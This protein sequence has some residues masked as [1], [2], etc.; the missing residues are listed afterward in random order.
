MQNAREKIAIYL[1]S[2]SGYCFPLLSTLGGVF[3]LTLNV[4]SPTLQF[5]Q[6]FSWVLIIVGLIWAGNIKDAKLRAEQRDLANRLAEYE[7][8]TPEAIPQIKRPIVSQR[9]AHSMQS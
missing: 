3:G 6:S 7:K 1:T 9:R 8:Q 5:P 4:V 2:L